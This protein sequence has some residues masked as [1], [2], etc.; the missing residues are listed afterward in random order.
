MGQKTQPI[1]GMDYIASLGKLG[2]NY[3]YA[4]SIAGLAVAIVMSLLTTWWILIFYAIFWV[5]CAPVSIKIHLM[6]REVI[7]TALVQGYANGWYAHKVTAH[8]GEGQSPFTES[9]CPPMVSLT[10]LG[11]PCIKAR[12]E[13]VPPFM[14]LM[15]VEG[16]IKDTSV[17]EGDQRDKLG[18]PRSGQT[19]F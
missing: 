19:P 5:I 15:G 17:A 3:S 12:D 1:M 2:L 9:P 14:R 11:D 18:S 7:E 6:G 8:V 16:D 4:A 10:M 13:A